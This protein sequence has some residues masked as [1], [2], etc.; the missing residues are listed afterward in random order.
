M[1][2]CF[3]GPGPNFFGQ[4]FAAGGPLD[5]QHNIVSALDAWVEK[6]IPPQ[7]IVATK[8]VGDTATQPPL[9]TYPLC[10]YPY[11]GRWTGRGNVN[12]AQN[13]RCVPGPR[14]NGY[15]DLY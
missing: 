9:R 8:Y 12:D 15:R 2:H 4:P 1:S 14:G 5:P 11:E 7:T 3:L 10:R 6:G 13:Y